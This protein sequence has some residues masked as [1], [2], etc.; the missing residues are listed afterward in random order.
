MVSPTLPPAFFRERVVSV[1]R[2]PKWRFWILLPL[3]LLPVG[4][5]V[6]VPSVLTY[7]QLTYGDQRQQAADL[8]SRGVRKFEQQRS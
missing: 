1:L 5:V 7:A 4:V 8:N 6:S 3:Y 2:I